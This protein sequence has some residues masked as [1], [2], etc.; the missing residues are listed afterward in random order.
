MT[1]RSKTRKAARRAERAVGIESMRAPY[2]RSDM[3]LIRRAINEGWEIPDKAKQVIAAG[4]KDTSVES[5]SD[6]VCRSA[7]QTQILIRQ[8]GWIE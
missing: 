1:I 8:L 5:R 6:R 4:L 7:M 3:A 2:T